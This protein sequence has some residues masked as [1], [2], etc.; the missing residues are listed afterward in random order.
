MAQKGTIGNEAASQTP[1][2]NQAARPVGKVRNPLTVFILMLVTLGIYGLYWYYCILED[3]RNWRG[4]GWS[5][6]L[7]LI[8]L[9]LL[10]IPLIALPWLIPAYIGRMYEEAGLEKP[11]TGM[12]GFW[13]FLPLIGS[14]VWVFKVQGRMNE[15]WEMQQ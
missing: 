8:F 7:F 5:G 15:F 11:I 2:R 14:I 1:L 10:G 9:L 6:P 12:A 3:L 4:Q 13:V